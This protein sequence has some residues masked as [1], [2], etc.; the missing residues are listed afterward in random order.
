MTAEAQISDGR[1]ENLEY[2]TVL[3]NLRLDADHSPDGT[4]VV[5]ITGDDA[6]RGTLRME[7][8]ARLTDQ[9]G[10]ILAAT[11]GL[12]QATLIR[13]DDVTATISGDLE[14]QGPLDGGTLAADMTVNQGLLRL[15]NT[16]G[17]G[18]TTLDVVEVGGGPENLLTDSDAEPEV[19]A[20]PVAVEL[21][22]SVDIP[23]QFYVRGRGLESEWSGDIQ[24]SG[25]SDAPRIVGEIQVVRGQFDLLGNTFT[26]TDGEVSLTGGQRIDPRLN[27]EATNESAGDITAIISVTGTAN[28]PEIELTSIPSLPEDEVMARVLFGTALEDL[29]P[30]EALQAANAVRV[31][32]GLGG[33]GPDITEVVAS[34][35][36]V[37]T[38]RFAGGDTGPAVEVGKYLTEGVYVGVEQGVESDSTSVNVEVQ[39]TPRIS[40]E[41]N[42]ST[43]GSDIGVNWSRDY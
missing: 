40:L 34:T 29:G 38:I 14:F 19:A 17:G 24:I 16:L 18:V 10:L 32:S 36:G 35:I 39:L 11:G 6:G 41:G 5:T 22:V 9:D 13:R 4:V 15:I 2:G 12:Q 28:D 43:R 42:T 3:T 27:I 37:D 20:S 30:V 1:Y 8:R 25:S 7:A 26:F 23:N 31:L 21:D 33:G